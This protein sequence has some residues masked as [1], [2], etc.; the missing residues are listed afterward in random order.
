M[1]RK[2]ITSL[3]VIVVLNLLIKPIYIFVIDPKVQNIVGTRDYGF[4]FSLFGF[5]W[6]LNILLD[7]GITN[8]NNRDISRHSHLLNK[9]LSNLI[10]IKLALGGVY[11]LVLFAIAF[12]VGYN[13]EQKQILVF[14]SSTSS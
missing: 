1:N 10:S 6:L 12:L 2:F 5:S 13:Q 8:F 11:F 14:W 3:A 9:Y 4:Y 7:F